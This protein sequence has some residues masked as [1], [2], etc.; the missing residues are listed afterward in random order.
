MI[1]SCVE[2][3]MNLGSHQENFNYDQ[4]QVYVLNTILLALI[5]LVLVLLVT[6]FLWNNA[7]VE[8]VSFV[9]PCKSVVH[10]L[11]LA[12]LLDILFCK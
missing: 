6:K 10:L 8:L 12:I 4:K 3:M 2:K 9:K 7:L 11:G 5:W 1:V